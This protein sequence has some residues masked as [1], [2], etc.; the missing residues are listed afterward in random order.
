MTRL[1]ALLWGIAIA[2]V[3]GTILYLAMLPDSLAL[4]SF[5]LTRNRFYYPLVL[6]GAVDAVMLVTVLTSGWWLPWAMRMQ[7][8]YEYRGS[9]ARE[10]DGE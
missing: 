7:E 6:T 8:R 3:H 9:G 10:E 4:A 2:C 5:I 1:S